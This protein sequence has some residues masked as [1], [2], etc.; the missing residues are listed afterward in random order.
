MPVT[1]SGSTL[2]S[3]VKSS[4]LSIGR[5]ELRCRPNFVHPPRHVRPTPSQPCLDIGLQDKV[6]Q[7]SWQVFP[8]HLGA[9][10]FALPSTLSCP[11]G[12]QRSMIFFAMSAD[13]KVANA[14]EQLQATLNV[15]RAERG[16]RI[17][18]FCILTTRKSHAKSGQ[19]V[20]APA[21]PVNLLSE[22]VTLKECRLRA[23]H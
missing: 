5:Q 3:L 16:V 8:G 2:R 4:E 23:A 14:E 17:F 1:L 12:A 13:G 11:V 20:C 7:A 22:F 10:M 18:R 9:S 6:L 21:A 15:S 19:P